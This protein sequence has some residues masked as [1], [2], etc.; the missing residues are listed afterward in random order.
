MATAF[1]LT[2][3]QNSMFLSAELTKMPWHYL[4]QIVVDVPNERLD[5]D[6]MG[7]AW[8]ELLMTHPELRSVVETA[9][10]GRLMQRMG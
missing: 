6:A 4:E 10:E 3:L 5:A 8:S 9:N 7:R 2:P 1:P